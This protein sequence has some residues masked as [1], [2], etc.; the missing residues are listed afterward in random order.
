MVCFDDRTLTPSQIKIYSAQ[1]LEVRKFHTPVPIVYSN[2]HKD[3]WRNELLLKKACIMGDLT[4]K[5]GFYI[6]GNNDAAYSFTMGEAQRYI[7]E[8]RQLIEQRQ[9]ENN[10]DIVLPRFFV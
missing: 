1:N 7:V 10:L 8:N 2:L 3:F 5:R 6:P 4:H 9:K